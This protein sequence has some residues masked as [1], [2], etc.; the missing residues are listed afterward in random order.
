MSAL[1]SLKPG[2]VIHR[3]RDHQRESALQKKSAKRKVTLQMLAY[4]TCGLTTFIVANS[5]DKQVQHYLSN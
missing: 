4:A 2:S 3:N 5:V 1:P